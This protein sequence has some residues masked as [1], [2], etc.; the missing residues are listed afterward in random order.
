MST[1][2]PGAGLP[3]PPE[4][5]PFPWSSSWAVQG[6]FVTL[7]TGTWGKNPCSATQSCAT[8]NEWLIVQPPSSHLYNGVSGTCSLP[9]TPSSL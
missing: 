7:E 1:R 4:Q 9:S 8:S 5:L 2:R 3:S 6:P